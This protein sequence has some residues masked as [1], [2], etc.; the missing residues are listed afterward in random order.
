M[1]GG[2]KAGGTATLAKDQKAVPLE[3]KISPPLVNEDEIP[4]FP[5]RKS[6]SSGNLMTDIK[7]QVER[8]RLQRLSREIPDPGVESTN[9]G[10]GSED[11]I[12]DEK[13]WKR[14]E[15]NIEDRRQEKQK[16]T[17]TYS[18]PFGED[19]VKQVEAAIAKLVPK[20]AVWDKVPLYQ[21]GIRTEGG[22]FL[23]CG[24]GESS[25]GWSEDNE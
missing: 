3:E 1:L 19:F 16:L 21:K 15:K 17:R 13:S 6:L 18:Q 12:W 9:E 14:E 23:I 5:V 4:I 22:D 2:K 7:R 11:S 10:Q 8:K 24:K 20:I 25:D